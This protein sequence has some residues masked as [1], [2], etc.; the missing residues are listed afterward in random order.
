MHRRKLCRLQLS[1]SS[2]SHFKSRTAQMVVGFLLPFI[3]RHV[4]RRFPLVTFL[5]RLSL[6]NMMRQGL[7]SP[8]IFAAE[9]IRVGQGVFAAARLCVSRGE[10][11]GNDP[12]ESAR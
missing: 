8:R 6:F 9:P 1:V 5:S 10:N 11:A 2:F 7:A 12:V 3:T 4:I